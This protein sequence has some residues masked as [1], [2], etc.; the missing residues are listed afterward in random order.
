MIILSSIYGFSVKI[1]VIFKSNLRVLLNRFYPNLLFLIIPINLSI[2]DDNFGIFY[3]YSS[4]S[5]IDYTYAIFLRMEYF[6][7]LAIDWLS[8]FIAYTLLTLFTN[9][10]FYI[11]MR[12]QSN[13]CSN[14]SSSSSYFIRLNNFLN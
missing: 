10:E 7:F 6:S 13:I 4:E 2:Y 12:R 8:I 1:S 9:K 11:S 5:K 3:T 14:S